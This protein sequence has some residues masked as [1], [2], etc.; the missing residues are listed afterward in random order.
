MIKNSA[1]SRPFETGAKS[2]G[3]EEAKASHLSCRN[4]DFH[5]GMKEEMVNLQE[6]IRLS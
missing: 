1:D 4:I 2:G 3:L 5:G 6:R